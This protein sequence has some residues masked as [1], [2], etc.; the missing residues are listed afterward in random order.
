M[1]VLQVKLFKVIIHNIIIGK[2][3]NSSYIDETTAENLEKDIT[4]AIRE[5]CSNMKE[6]ISKPL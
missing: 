2:Y 4:K 1:G 6:E 3:F 5:V